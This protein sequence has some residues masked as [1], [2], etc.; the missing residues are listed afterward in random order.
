M[1]HGGYKIC[2]NTSMTGIAQRQK[3]DNGSKWIGESFL[4]MKW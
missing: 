1:L 2:E 3:G 4:H